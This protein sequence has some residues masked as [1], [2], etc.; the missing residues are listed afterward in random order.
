MRILLKVILF[1]I[2]LVLS[3]TVATS[4]FLCHFSSVLLSILSVV[5][6]LIAVLALLILK[7]PLAA[8]NAGIIAFVISPYGIPKLA[9]WLIDKLENFNCLLKSI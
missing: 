2:T 3:I 6:F 8:L 5:I 1:P 7:D 9:D 4:R